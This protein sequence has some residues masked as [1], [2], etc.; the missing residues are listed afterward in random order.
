LPFGDGASC[1]GTDWSPSRF[2]DFIHNS[3]DN[4]EHTLFREYSTTQGRWLTPD[5][6]ALRAINPRNPQSWNQYSYVMNDPCNLTDP[7]G[8]T[9]C[10]FNVRLEGNVT[11]KKVLQNL[12]DEIRRIFQSANVGLDVAFP[13]NISDYDLSVQ[14]NV[15]SEHVSEDA[16]GFTPHSGTTVFDYGSVYASRVEAKAPSTL[17]NS[18]NLGISLGRAGAHEIGHYLLQ[19]VDH[20]TSGLM[21]AKFP[22]GDALFKPD[23]NGRFSFDAA[24]AL[25]LLVDCQR[26][27]NPVPVI[28]DIRTPTIDMIDEDSLDY[29][30]LPVVVVG[31]PLREVVTSRIFFYSV[32]FSFDFDVFDEAP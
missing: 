15:G 14:Q 7:L 25:K 19:Q 17:Q 31:D 21:Q 26:R 5:P 30:F 32:T 16:L 29:E 4:L 11:D 8:L 12:K 22:Y 23:A 27:R 1:T 24:Q 10:T 20:S 28:E 18:A 9:P 6:A 2:T 3:E 13:S